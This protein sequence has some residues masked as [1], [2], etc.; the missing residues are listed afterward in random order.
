MKQLQHP[1]HHR[2]PRKADAISVEND[3]KPEAYEL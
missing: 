1:R 2:Q 3:E